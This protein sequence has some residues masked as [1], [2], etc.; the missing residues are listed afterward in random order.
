MVNGQVFSCTAILT[1]VVITLKDI[2][3]GKI[4]ALVRGVNI[5]IETDDGWHGKCLRD[6]VQLVSIR[7][8]DH[9]AFIEEDEY[10]RALHGT[11][12]EWTVIL[13]QHQN[14]AVHDGNIIPNFERSNT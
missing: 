8:S 2:L 14:S 12:H 9:F 13:I 6:G 7:R 1:L 4:N 5:S 10:E 11:D 3:P